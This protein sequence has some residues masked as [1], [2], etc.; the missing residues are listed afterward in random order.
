M[1]TVRNFQVQDASKLVVYGKT[2]LNRSVLRNLWLSLTDVVSLGSV[3]ADGAG[4]WKVKG[5][6]VSN[7]PVRSAHKTL[8][9]SYL[10][11]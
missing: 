10:N 4:M 8:L 1:V 5:M 3:K 7:A 2:V 6:A 11:F 9:T